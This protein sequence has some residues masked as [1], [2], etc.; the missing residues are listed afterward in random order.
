M[1]KRCFTLFGIFLI[2]G[3]PAFGQSRSIAVQTGVFNFDLS[4]TGNSPSVALSADWA[5]TR[6]LVLEAATT[7]AFPEQQFGDRTRFVIPE[8]LVQYQWTLGK[9]A[10]Y[11]SGGVGAAIDVRDEIFGGTRTDLALSTG[12]GVRMNLSDSMGVRGDVRLR[13]FGTH[14][15]SS[16]AELRGG[17]FWRF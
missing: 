8:G 9:F 2:A 10:P 1:S 15:S 11:V 7:V 17:L 3:I 14:F 13:G 6:H 5:G 16:A 4:G 12:G